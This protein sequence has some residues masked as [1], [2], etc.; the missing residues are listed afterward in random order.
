MWLNPWQAQPVRRSSYRP[1]YPTTN[2]SRKP[3]H[4]ATSRMQWQGTLLSFMNHAFQWYNCQKPP[5]RSDLQVT[6]EERD[7][8]LTRDCRLELRSHS[9][10]CGDRLFRIKLV[11]NLFHLYT[12]SCGAELSKREDK[13]QKTGPRDLRSLLCIVS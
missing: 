2:N 7:L 10:C 3:W 1:V 12:N 5:L 4:S 9:T 11:F 13:P 8:F 6:T